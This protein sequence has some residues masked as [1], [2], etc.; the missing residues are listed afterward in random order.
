MFESKW[1]SSDLNINFRDVFKRMSFLSFYFDCLSFKN[2]ETFIFKKI[3]FTL[4]FYVSKQ[5]RC[6]IKKKKNIKV[7]IKLKNQAIIGSSL[8]LGIAN[9]LV[10]VCPLWEIQVFW[11][12]PPS[13]DLPVTWL[14]WT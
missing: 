12:F 2:Q 13:A 8:L 14:N 5:I 11:V 1:A 9:A 3:V 7:W 10:V 4:N 6:S